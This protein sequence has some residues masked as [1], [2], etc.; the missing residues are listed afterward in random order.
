M[1]I[2]P[3]F[4]A[5]AQFAE[6]GEPS[7]HALN[8]PSVPAQSLLACNADTGDAGRHATALQVTP[9]SATVRYLVG[10]QL[11]GPLARVSIQPA[12]CR[13]GIGHGD[14]KY[15]PPTPPHPQTKL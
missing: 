15:Q 13:N 10:M 3:P 6:T 14:L 8:N 4:E 12:N 7:M 11:V 5:D 2:E 1:K 9:A